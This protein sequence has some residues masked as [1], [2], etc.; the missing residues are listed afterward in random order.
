MIKRTKNGWQVVSADGSKELSPP[1]LAYDEAERQEIEI[2]KR[3]PLLV[4]AMDRGMI[5][6]T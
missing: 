4:W 2:G 1:D 5:R 3:S 6:K